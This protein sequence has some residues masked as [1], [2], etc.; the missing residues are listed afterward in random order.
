MIKKLVLFSILGILGLN[1][2]NA[3]NTD[4]EYIIDLND[5]DVKHLNES[6]R[7]LLNIL[8]QQSVDELE[9]DIQQ[10]TEDKTQGRISEEEYEKRKQMASDAVSDKIGKSIDILTAAELHINT[11]E[12]FT[13]SF[14]VDN[15]NVKYKNDPETRSLSIQFEEDTDSTKTEKNKLHRYRDDVYFGVGFTNWMN[16]DNERYDDP[17]K[18]LSGGSSMYYEIGLKSS[19]FFKRKNP[20]KDLEY[21]S[22]TSFNYGF[23]LISRYYHFNDKTFSINKEDNGISTIDDVQI[24][25]SVFSQTALEVPVTLTHYFGKKVR[26]SVSVSAGFYG[27]VNIRTRQKIKYS[28]DNEDYKAKWINDFNTNTVYGGAIAKIGFSNVI[29]TGRY[30]FSKLFKSSSD[31]EVYPYTIGLTVEL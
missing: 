29:L 3:Q 31:I 13:D 10:L 19:T 24:T 12:Q 21:G 17:Q 14:H 6:E 30:N 5:F 4:S 20:N 15:I 27:G 22:R 28:V 16:S 11:N 23:T 18:K 25:K 8:I 2:L 7:L 9:K 26:S 1:I